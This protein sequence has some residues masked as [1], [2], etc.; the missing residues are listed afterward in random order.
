M[1]NC[2][3]I[4]TATL[5]NTSYSFCSQALTHLPSFVKPERQP[6]LL[7]AAS[8]RMARKPG[9]HSSPPH[10]EGKLQMLH[11]RSSRKSNSPQIKEEMEHKLALK[12]THIF[13]EQVM[14]QLSTTSTLKVLNTSCSLLLLSIKPYKPHK[15]T[16]SAAELFLNQSEERR[17]NSH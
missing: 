5:P 9:C 10:S 11:T 6:H 7:R 3:L 15:A 17:S 1:S 8:A 13:N 4:T 14:N 16:V 2:T 12:Q